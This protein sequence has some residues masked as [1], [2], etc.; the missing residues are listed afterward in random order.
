MHTNTH[1][2]IQRQTKRQLERQTHTNVVNNRLPLLSLSRKT[3]DIMIW[4]F[5]RLGLM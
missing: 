5:V 1:K 4:A 2:E 3:A